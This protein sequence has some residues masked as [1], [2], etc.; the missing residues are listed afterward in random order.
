MLL[1]LLISFILLVVFGIRNSILYD[2]GFG[3]NVDRIFD[4]SSIQMFN[5]LNTPPARK[6]LF[7]IHSNFFNYSANLILK[8]IFFVICIIIINI[9]NSHLIT[10]IL[11]TIHLIIGI[12]D[13]KVFLN[14]R[15]FYKFTPAKYKSLYYFPYKAC[16][17][18]P[19]YQT[20]LYILL[21]TI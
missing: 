2:K 21:F 11:S 10:N 5:N 6:P 20:V 15:K 12:I 4:L 9:A 16:I 18:G 17:C 19:I 3:N 1:S 13:W 14:R 7:E 8:F